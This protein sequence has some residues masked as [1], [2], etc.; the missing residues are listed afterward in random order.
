MTICLR[1]ICA[2]LRMFY[3]TKLC[4]TDSRAGAQDAIAGSAKPQCHWTEGWI[5]AVAF[6]IAVISAGRERE[7]V[8]WLPM[9]GPDVTSAMGDVHNARYT[10]PAGLKPEDAKDRRAARKAFVEL[11]FAL[12]DAGIATSESRRRNA[13][14]KVFSSCEREVK[15]QRAN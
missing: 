11:Q 5:D 7:V 15:L 2:K 13:C 9:T 1:S 4:A 12:L 3:F 8:A 6:R 14:S 10:N